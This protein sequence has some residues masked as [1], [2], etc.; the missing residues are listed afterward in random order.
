MFSHS[1]AL[2][3]NVLVGTAIKN[4]LLESTARLP[5]AIQYLHSM[6]YQNF[7]MA[8]GILTLP[9]ILPILT[10]LRKRLVGEVAL[11][12]LGA[13]LIGVLMHSFIIWVH[14]IFAMEMFHNDVLY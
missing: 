13:L 6:L 9:I 1:Y 10:V 14:V 12:A 7:G 11:A 3:S 5:T 4:G 8:F 2:C